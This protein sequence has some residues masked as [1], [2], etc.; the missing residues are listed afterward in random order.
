MPRHQTSEESASRRFFLRT[1][2]PG[3]E[4]PAP[5][6]PVREDAPQ[7]PGHPAQP[8]PQVWPSAC[9]P[10]SADWVPGFEVSL[11]E[12]DEHHALRVIRLREGDRLLGLD[13]HGSEWPL[14]VTSASK[15]GLTAVILAQPRRESAPGTPGSDLARVHLALSPPRPQRMEAMIERLTQLGVAR[16]T[17][18]VAER[19]PE[20]ARRLGDAKWS[21]L[22]RT[23]RE[24]CKQS[25]RLWLPR[26]DEPAPLEACL[27]AAD[28]RAFRLDRDGPAR[29]WEL[30]ARE[31]SAPRLMLIGPE[32]GFSQAELERLEAAGV[33]AARLAPH[34][35]RIETAAELACGLAVHASLT[36]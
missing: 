35:L 2:E 13:G 5:C 10:G 30:L 24:A 22:Q 20:H 3:D 33:A 16:I 7:R 11:I 27:A 36:P 15:R 23:A 34:V 31:A 28:S 32:G 18:L 17:P 26:I 25:G 6:A 12:E 21:R 19:S 29:L 4:T 8:S 1:P 14:R 9:G